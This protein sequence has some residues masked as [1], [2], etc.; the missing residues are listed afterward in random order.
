MRETLFQLNHSGD[1]GKENKMALHQ[2]IILKTSR[3]SAGNL[4]HTDPS[5]ELRYTLH[6]VVSNVL[7][8]P[9]CVWKKRRET[10]SIFLI[11]FPWCFW[12]LFILN[13]LVVRFLY[14]G[15]FQR[16]SINNENERY[17]L[18]SNNTP[19]PQSAALWESRCNHCHLNFC[20]TSNLQLKQSR[21]TLALTKLF[22]A[23][24]NPA[25]TGPTTV[26][27]PAKSNTHPT[28]KMILCTPRMLQKWFLLSWPW[29]IRLP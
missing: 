16:L 12:L 4:C 14:S 19:E 13:Y 20:S 11:R 8:C 9:L 6:Q 7:L 27:V 28:L 26:C 3:R 24:L 25:P 1:V 10:T 5:T 2:E 22:F 21:E 18:P 23:A 29:D 17:I 15:I